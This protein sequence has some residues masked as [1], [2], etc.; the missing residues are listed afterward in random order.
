MATTADL[1][2]TK[3]GPASTPSNTTIVY[4][5]TAT[6]SGPSDAST[7]TLTE[8][9]P[10]GTTF[11][12]VNQTSG[13]AFACSG[14]GPVV[15]TIAT[16]AAG[17]SAAFQFTFNVPPSAASGSTITDTATIS[18]TTPDSNATNNS[19]TAST[20]VGASIP[21]LSPLMLALLALAV[22]ALALVAL[23]R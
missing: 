1:S 2:V 14:S 19:A 18:A 17:A 16:F 12:S 21:A 7:V 11:V 5:V 22:S 20:T 8:T 3:T 9:V 23:R 6:N 13:P 15:C 4:N 10:A